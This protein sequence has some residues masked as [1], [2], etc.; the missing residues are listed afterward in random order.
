MVG[1]QLNLKEMK[2]SHLNRNQSL[3]A[4]LLPIGGG[5]ISL[6]WVLHLEMKFSMLR[7]FHSGSGT[8]MA[9]LEEELS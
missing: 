9:Q 7:L 5:T 8:L 3:K 1:C 6:S 2:R 4:I